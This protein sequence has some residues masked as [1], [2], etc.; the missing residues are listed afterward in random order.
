MCSTLVQL[1]H[2]NARVTNLCAAAALPPRCDRAL[3]K[4]GM[5]TA[6]P[7]SSLDPTKRRPDNGD[8]PTT[9]FQVLQVKKP[10]R[11]VMPTQNGPKVQ[12]IPKVKDL[13]E[14]T[15]VPLPDIV[16]Q[17]LGDATIVVGVDIETADWVDKKQPITKEPKGFYHICL[18]VNASQKMFQIG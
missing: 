4:A 6:H 3:L 10:K 7:S 9:R 13:T 17:K 11:F 5:A 15:A 2:M 18:P 8:A 1:L 16:V 14:S 12:V